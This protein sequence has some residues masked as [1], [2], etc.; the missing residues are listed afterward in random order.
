M[1]RADAKRR[2]KCSWKGMNG[3]E[4]RAMM[5]ERSHGERRLGRETKGRSRSWRN[6]DRGEDEKFNWRILKGERGV[7]VSN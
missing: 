3:E 4:A 6:N 1:W 2:G 5:E 7:T